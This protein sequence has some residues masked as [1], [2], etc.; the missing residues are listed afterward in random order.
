MNWKTIVL[1]LLPFSLFGQVP[2][3][4][5]FACSAGAGVYVLTRNDILTHEY[6]SS[7]L[8][9]LS[10]TPLFNVFPKWTDFSLTVD[11]PMSFGY[12]IKHDEL[13]NNFFFADLP[14][15]AE[16]NIGHGSTTNF[17][18]FFGF[19]AGA[20]YGWQIMG[21]GS[22]SGGVFTGGFRTWLGPFAA[23]F[24]Y[25]YIHSNNFEAFNIHRITVTITIGP[26][27]KKVKQMNKISNFVKPV[28]KG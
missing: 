11:A 9:A 12:H 20:G 13:P 14:M 28:H 10:V 3:N 27:V 16:L 21:K 8:P 18:S 25:A 7:P 1:L 19:F 22:Q 17:H 6:T 2:F 26:W 15:T 5:R 23:T 24:R 4:K